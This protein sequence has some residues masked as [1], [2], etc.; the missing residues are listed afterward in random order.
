MKALALVAICAAGC[1][2]ALV[3]PAAGGPAWRQLTASRVVLKTNLSEWTAKEALDE[4]ETAATHIAGLI[5][6][7]I[8]VAERPEVVLFEDLDDYRELGAPTW[9]GGHFTMDPRDP[10]TPPTVVLFARVGWVASLP[11]VLQSWQHEYTHFLLSRLLQ[12]TPTWLGEGLAQLLESARIDLEQGALVIGGSESGV[13]L[14]Q[15][16]PI[17]DLIVAD[18]RTF[19]AEANRDRYY[20]AA[21]GLVYLLQ[22]HHPDAFRR[23][24][25][26]LHASASTDEA[27]RATGLEPDALEREIHSE[28]SRDLPR[29]QRLSSAGPVH[30]P[31][32]SM[33]LLGDDEVHLLWARLRPWEDPSAREK[34]RA[35]LEEA[36]RVAPDSEELRRLRQQLGPR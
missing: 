24:L 19:Y 12:R 36:A 22:F 26:A 17:K 5:L 34:A 31:P 33:R 35:D 20:S 1:G 16:P 8:P 2:H 13:P 18:Q 23:L 6:L 4:L 9:S 21:W 10:E 29:A 3:C 25:E 11:G 7:P 32:D 28:F 14:E 30:K 27:W 15:W